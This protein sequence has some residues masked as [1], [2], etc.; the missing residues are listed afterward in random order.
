MKE[1]KRNQCWEYLKKRGVKMRVRPGEVNKEDRRQ[2]QKKMAKAPNSVG[3]GLKRRQ[4]MK[5]L[6]LRLLT[7]LVFVLLGVLCLLGFICSFAVLMRQHNRATKSTDYRVRQLG[8]KPGYATYQ[9]R[10]CQQVT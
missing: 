10:D 5:G 8:F 4:Q 6:F 3:F 9:L 7:C 1:L 2:K